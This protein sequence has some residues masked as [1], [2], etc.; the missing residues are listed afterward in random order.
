[1][2]AAP[3]TQTDDGCQHHR[4]D[5]RHDHLTSGAPTKSA[6]VDLEASQEEQE[7]QAEHR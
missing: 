1:M 4:T 6:D 5:Q 7:R 2:P 3:K